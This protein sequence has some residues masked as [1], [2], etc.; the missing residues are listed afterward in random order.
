MSEKNPEGTARER[1]TRRSGRPTEPSMYGPWAE[2]SRWAMEEVRRNGHLGS[3][4]LRQW[5]V[6]GVDNADTGVAVWTKELDFARTVTTASLEA[7]AE[8]TPWNE[9]GVRVVE[10]TTEKWFD[11]L[12]KANEESWRLFRRRLEEATASSDD[13][14]ERYDELVDATVDASTET[15]REAE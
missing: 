11:A 13:V 4:L 7:T 12:L 5:S 15:L 8:V 9:R 1:A 3:A 6:A 14:L 2:M 10:E